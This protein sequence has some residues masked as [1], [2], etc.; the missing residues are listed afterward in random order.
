MLYGCAAIQRNLNRLVNM[1]ILEW[2]H[3]R[4]TKGIKGSEY[5]PYKERLRE[6]AP[7]SL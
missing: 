3:Q 1:D 5:L 6:L 4:T 2:I 7:F